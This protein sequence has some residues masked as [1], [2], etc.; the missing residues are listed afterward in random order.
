MRGLTGEMSEGWAAGGAGWHDG[1]ARFGGHVRGL[2]ERCQ[3]AYHAFDDLPRLVDDLRI[4]AVNAE[5]ASARAGD[6]G[7]AVRVLTH[8][9][10][11]AVTRLLLVVP[12]MVA[13]KRCTYTVAGT[14]LR[15]ARDVGKFEAAGALVIAAGRQPLPALERAWRA[16]LRTLEL[17]AASL[18]STHGQLVGVVRSV[19]EV[20]MQ[21]E[22]IAANIAIEATAAGPHEAELSAIAEA[23]RERVNAMRRMV[24]GA[25]NGLRDAAETNLALAEFGRMGRE[26]GRR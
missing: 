10:T 8:F 11:E 19:R 20:M 2:Y 21:T 17:A 7:R 1:Y 3:T 18:S 4:L 15:A 13:L 12:E 24:E 6:F 25:G 22:I 5:L 23:M 26:E 14:I 16:R 9:A